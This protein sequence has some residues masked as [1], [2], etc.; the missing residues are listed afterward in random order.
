M[1]SINR[2]RKPRRPRPTFHQGKEKRPG[3]TERDL[4]FK[5]R[6]Q[7][8]RAEERRKKH[9]ESVKRRF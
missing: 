6:R 2:D 5:E 1:V 3:E 4:N 9:L 8:A 7:I